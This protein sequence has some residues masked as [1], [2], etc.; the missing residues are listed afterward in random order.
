[1]SFG[2]FLKNVATFGRHG[3]SQEMARHY[4]ASCRHLEQLHKEH[5]AL[6]AN[7]EQA[8]NH[9]TSVRQNAAEQCS[10]NWDDISHLLSEVK[11]NL[12]V[13]A[14]YIDPELSK[15][16]EGVSD[17]RLG[18]AY[19]N[20]QAGAG[21]NFFLQYQNNKMMQ[22][23]LQRYDPFKP[24]P[25]RNN[26]M[27]YYVGGAA[28]AM[29]LL[30]AVFAGLNEANEVI[31]QIKEKE[32][33]VNKHIASFR[34]ANAEI[35]V[36]L[37]SMQQD[38][39]ELEAKSALLGQLKEKLIDLSTRYRLQPNALRKIRGYF[40]Q[41][42]GMNP[43]TSKELNKLGAAYSAFYQ[44]TELITNLLSKEYEPRKK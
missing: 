12:P 28:I 14:P 7:L 5:E 34:S 37:K 38:T 39:D 27:T 22:S 33:E 17:Q 2:D 20:S 9:L 26:N 32:V 10:K 42:F 44:C 16:L 25:S 1:M 4:E 8:S 13:L 23:R 30:N 15:L 11:L 19:K 6:Y 36:V 24:V 21:L 3:K 31:R 29:E 35:R 43:L 18:Q 40:R 41:Q